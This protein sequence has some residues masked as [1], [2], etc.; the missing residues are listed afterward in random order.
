LTGYYRKFIKNYGWIS[1]PLT[2]LLIKNVFQWRED[3]SQAFRALKSAICSAPVLAMSD[4]SKPFILE[5]DACDIGIWVIIAAIQK[6]RHYLQGGPFV[7]KTNHISLKH[8]LDQRLTYTLQHKGPC[9]LLGLDYIVQ[10]ERGEQ[11]C[12]CFI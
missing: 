9:K 2:N 3:T 6:W 4:F 7:I 10:K 8:L 12:K 5:T 1:R 11:S